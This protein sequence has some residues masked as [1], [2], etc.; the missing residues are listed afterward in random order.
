MSACLRVEGTRQRQMSALQNEHRRPPVMEQSKIKKLHAGDSR[1]CG[2]MMQPCKGRTFVVS[3][4]VQM[5]WT[6]SGR[7]RNGGYWGLGG[8]EPESVTS[9][10]WKSNCAGG[11]C[12]NDVSGGGGASGS[13]GRNSDH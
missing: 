12:G 5:K 11:S 8:R 3:V 13:D 7:A 10:R 9:V 4:A 2:S 1:I 6:G